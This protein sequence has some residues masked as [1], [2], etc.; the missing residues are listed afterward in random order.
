[1]DSRVYSN[2][3]ILF[4]IFLIFSTNSTLLF[5]QNQEE[6]LQKEIQKYEVLSQNSTSKPF[7]FFQLGRKGLDLHL[8]RKKN[9]KLYQDIRF[10]DFGVQLDSL[11][12]A[13][14][15]AQKALILYRKS[16][17]EEKL[18]LSKKGIAS[19]K[20]V[21]NLNEALAKA[22]ADVLLKAPYNVDYQLLSQKSPYNL[23]QFADTTQVLRNS[24]I[25]QTKY[26][27]EH[28]PKT[29][30]TNSIKSLQKR[31]LKQ[32]IS[33][34]GL[35]YKGTGAGYLYERY[36]NLILQDYSKG[37]LSKILKEFYGADYD[38]ANSAEQNKYFQVLQEIAQN[39]KLDVL[40]FLCEL[41]LNYE[42]ATVENKNLYVEFIQ[43]LAPLDIAFVAVQKLTA[44]SI[45]DKN[46]QEAIEIYQKYQSIFPKKQR[47]FE[48]IISMLQDPD[49][50]LKL[51]ILTKNINS[52]LDESS[53]VPLGEASDLLFCRKNF[54][55]GQ[56]IY[57][58]QNQKVKK[59]N[60]SINTISHEVPQSISLD[61]NTLVLFGNYAYLPEYRIEIRQQADKLG[62][63][64]L[65][66][67]EKQK[68]NSWGRVRAFPSPINSEEYDFNLTFTAK[69]QAVF[70]ASDRKQMEE[71]NKNYRPKAPQNQLYF[72]GREEFNTD[73]YVSEW[74]DTNQIW[75]EPINLGE[76]I[77]TP[78]A[79]AMPFLH[80]DGK[81]L[82]FI[83]DGHYGLG[84]A[85]IFMSKRL[86]PN[87]WTQW[88]EPINLGKSINTTSK[89][90]FYLSNSGKFAY[91]VRKNH[92]NQS[93]DIYRFE[94]PERFRPETTQTLISINGK[95][96][97]SEGK[98]IETI[99][100]WEDLRT[101]K[102]EGQI[103]TNF[104]DGSFEINLP[105]GKY[106]GFYTN[107]K[108]HYSSAENIDLTLQNAENQVFNKKIITYSFDEIIKNKKRLKLSNIFFDFDKTNLK[109]ESFPELDRLVK[110]LKSHPNFKVRIEGH[111]DTV[112]QK[113]YNLNLSQKRAKAV[114]DYLILQ[115]CQTEKVLHKG[116][117]DTKP[118]FDNQ[119]AKNRAKNRR[120]EFSLR[121]LE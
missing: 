59:L 14:K 107:K 35:R 74:N 62:K 20:V 104:N 44:K 19:S 120:V 93:Y 41:N 72:H 23:P 94:V 58:F 56:D 5:G 86:N 26:Y 37:E 84:S 79:E 113:A 22:A 60:S 115:G 77:N 47:D 116:Y 38:F 30:S 31:L 65:F 91:I 114:A 10:K 34:L 99:V 87:S 33:I 28:F 64:D 98:G 97:N 103:K 43:N 42:G 76:I 27:L 118:L 9:E 69:Q 85:D 61:G 102:L 111:T 32:Y 54:G 39:N 8:L 83:S 49:D 63:G 50:E 117:G 75:S 106:Y 88:S 112:G 24:L 108:D 46:W 55:T 100:Y 7:V 40:S 119:T 101:G 18:A 48:R 70:F 73:I 78:F 89:D 51:T 92:Q 71:K 81:T 11:K 3:K 17:Q 68:D 109:K 21:F 67:S 13:Y 90:A 16:S 2:V 57:L 105:K 29:R 66:Y 45:R 1:M 25:N 6:N 12:I 96:Q 15:Y 4:F 36:C 52:D 80:P 121:R 82:Y 110:I 53:P 95:V